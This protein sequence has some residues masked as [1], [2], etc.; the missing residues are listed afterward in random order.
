LKG[1]DQTTKGQPEKR[2]IHNISNIAT[3][4]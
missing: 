4:I 3:N 2:L 1:K